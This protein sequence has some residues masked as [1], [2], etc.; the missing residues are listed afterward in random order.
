MGGEARCCSCVPHSHCEFMK[1]KLEKQN[2]CVEFNKLLD[3]AFPMNTDVSI[4]DGDSRGLRQ[5]FT[6]F[7]KKVKEENLNK[8]KK[9][10]KYKTF[11]NTDCEIEQNIVRIQNIGFEEAHRLTSCGHSVGDYRDKNYGTNKYDGDEKCVGCESIKEERER[12]IGIMEK[13]EVKIKGKHTGESFCPQCEDV[14]YNQALQDIIN[15][16]NTSTNNITKSQED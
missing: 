4:F 7:F 10:T 13:N 12:I 8:L 15:K 6:D 2:T 16:I 1:N 9:H 11:H 14:G 3:L 5:R